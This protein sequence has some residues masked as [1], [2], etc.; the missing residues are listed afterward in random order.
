M[1]GSRLTGKELCGL[2]RIGNL[3]SLDAEGILMHLIIQ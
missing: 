3:S 1:N 2:Q